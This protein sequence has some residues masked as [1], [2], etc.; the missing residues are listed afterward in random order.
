MS[1]NKIII[2]VTFILQ[3]NFKNVK[4]LQKLYFLTFN[5]LKYKKY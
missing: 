4:K 3:Y 2:V 1:S 5:K